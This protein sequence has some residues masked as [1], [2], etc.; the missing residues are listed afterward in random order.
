MFETWRPVMRWEKSH[1][2]SSHGNIRRISRDKTRKHRTFPL[3]PHLE[4]NG[5]RRIMLQYKGNIKAAS[6]HILVCEAF[7][8]ER[9]SR[10]YQVAHNDG[11]PSNN[12]YKNLRWATPKNNTADKFMHGTMLSGQNHGGSIL[13]EIDVVQIRRL[14]MTN[15]KNADIAKVFNVNRSTIYCIKYKKTWKSFKETT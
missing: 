7:H 9:P 12:H 4:M 8:G 2:V 1:E 11:N 3:T 5:Y 15:M 10:I 14:L 13:T 6:V